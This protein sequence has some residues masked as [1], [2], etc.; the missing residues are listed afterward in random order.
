MGITILTDSV[1]SSVGSGLVVIPLKEVPDRLDTVA[2]WKTDT[3]NGAKDRFIEF[4]R[5]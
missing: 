3:T 1:R 2:I 4:L 5:S